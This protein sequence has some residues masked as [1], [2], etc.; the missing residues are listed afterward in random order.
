MHKGFLSLTNFFATQFKTGQ[1][2]AIAKDQLVMW[3]RPHPK[4]ATPADPVGP[5][6]DFQLVRPSPC[7]HLTTEDSVAYPLSCALQFQDKMW[8]VVL[9]SADGQLTLSSTDS[10]AQTFDVKA[11]VNKL[12]LPI[13]AGGFMKATLTRN[14]QTVLDFQPEG[15]TFNLTPATFNYNAFVAGR[16]AQ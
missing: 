10:D 8:A 12:S 16:T 1:A 11:G 13:A 14:G 15:F 4:N 3:A 6:T 5:P 9:A 7:L 2:P